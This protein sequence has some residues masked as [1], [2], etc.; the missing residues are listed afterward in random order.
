M[1]V[2]VGADTA[3]QSVLPHAAVSTQRSPPRTRPGRTSTIVRVGYFDD[4]GKADILLRNSSGDTQV[5]EVNGLTELAGA[6][7]GIAP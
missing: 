6:D 4:D 3:G 7:F 2:V 5:W 1:V